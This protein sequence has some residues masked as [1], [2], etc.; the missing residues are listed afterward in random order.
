MLGYIACVNDMKYRRRMIGCIMILKNLPHHRKIIPGLKARNAQGANRTKLS[1]FA[2]YS[3]FTNEPKRTR[4]ATA[5]VERGSREFD[6]LH[7]WRNE[8]LVV[9]VCAFV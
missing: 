2:V 6:H 4:V 1:T 7:D 8:N 3:C 9:C 5:C